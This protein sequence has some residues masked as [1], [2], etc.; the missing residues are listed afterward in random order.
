[1][2]RLL[3][4]FA[5]LVWPLAAAADSPDSLRRAMALL[6]AG[7]GAGAMAAARPG[8]EI[9]GDLIA[10]HLLRDGQGDLAAYRA[11]VA[12]RADWPGLPYLIRQG[13]GALTPDTP[14]ETVRDWF[15][16]RP[17]ETAQGALRLT[18]AWEALGAP[19]RA[20]ALAADVW[21]RL[22]LDEETEAALLARHGRALADLHGARLEAM[23]W[24][25]ATEAAT[26]A[27][28]RVDPGPRALARARLALMGMEPGVDAAIAAVPPALAEDAGLAHARFVWRA[29]RDRTEDVIT[30]LHA[31]STSAA[32]LGQPEAWSNRRR[33]YARAAL[34]LGP[35]ERAYAIASRHFLDQGPEGPDP[36]ETTA[37][38]ADLEW[39]S[40][41]IAL[42]H[43]G[44]PELALFHFDRFAGAVST[45]ISLGRAGYWR[46]RALAAL[47]RP[48]EAAA[49]YAE[50][51]RHQSSF[52]GL[53][54][55]EA[56]NLPP[57][58]A[59]QGSETFAP[60]A[61]TGLSG[62]S[63]Y[64]AGVMLLA[65]GEPALAERFLTHLSE[66][67]PRAHAG[68]LAQDMLDRGED[69]IALSIA[70][71]VL[72]R[73]IVLPAALF[74]VPRDFPDA[75]PVPRDLALAITRR[76]SMFDPTARSPAGARGLMQLMPGTAGEVADRLGIAHDTGRLITDPAHNIA[77]GTAYLATLRDR[78]GPAPIL[79]AVAYNAGPSRAEDW[80]ATLGDPR[81]PGTD[82]ID[83][84][85][86]IPF[87]ETRAYV[88]R[89][90]ESILI[91]R[92]RL[93]QETPGLSLLLRGG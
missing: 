86:T 78:F 2:H 25:G 61:E 30:L 11:F 19:D 5:L 24:Q 82:L 47:G 43:L 89:V 81:A 73:G 21:T 75:L 7:D 88:M 6:R 66:R 59:L 90:T 3:L 1:M 16:P 71:R 60:L 72:R 54:A 40:G 9:A 69:H 84:I 27:L 4:L 41:F 85:E 13:E 38:F 58:P 62:D 18:E 48:A 37:D 31:R 22:P 12:R 42:R 70:R 53:L 92:L 17:P 49:A 39:L 15:G 28:P 35:P 76:E 50:G 80:I 83:W 26:R 52:Y 46:G 14:P 67:L 34:R 91:Y 32:A 56:A 51:A 64:R 77:L 55:A 74:P 36:D 10:W 29:R 65:A 20:R 57:D 68:A 93:G 44:D 87:R 8:G 45:P 33:L 79:L 23:L 63:V